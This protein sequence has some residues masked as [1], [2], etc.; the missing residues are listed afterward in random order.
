MDGLQCQRA[1]LQ[2]IACAHLM[3]DPVSRPC[4][5]PAKADRNDDCRLAR[6]SSQRREIQMV[7]VAVADED[8]REISECVAE[9]WR[10]LTP[11]GAGGEMTE[12]RIRKQ[13]HAIEVDEDG[14]VAEKGSI[15]AT[16][17]RPRSGWRP[18]TA[19]C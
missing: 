1:D 11:D 4:H 12:Q 10:H 5:E 15:S 16:T 6:K 19:T 8:C 14:R 17:A 18:S 2:S 3:D 7:P 13:T 9:H